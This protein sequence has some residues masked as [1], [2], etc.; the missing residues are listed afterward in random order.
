MKE[1]LQILPFLL[2]GGNYQWVIFIP[3]LWA[4]LIKIIN[5]IK[6]KIYCFNDITI[7]QKKHQ[8]GQSCVDHNA[9]YNYVLWWI[10]DENPTISSKCEKTITNYSR[11]YRTST[12]IC[13]Y[14][15]IPLYTPTNNVKLTW[16]NYEYNISV[17]EN[18]NESFIIIRGDIDKCKKLIDH[19]KAEYI[20]KVILVDD[21]DDNLYLLTYD[22]KNEQWDK[23]IIDVNKTFDNVINPNNINKKIINDLDQFI[24]NV[25]YYKKMGIPYKRGYL[26][27]GIPGTGKSSTIYAISSKM[28]RNMYKIFPKH[29]TSKTFIKAI[30]NIK[31]NSI[32]LMEEIDIHVDNR[33]N[34]KDN[35]KDDIKDYLKL[36]ISTILDILDGYQYLHNCIIILTTNYYDKLD[37]ALI[38]P[39]RIDMQIEFTELSYTDIQNIIKLYTS[40]NLAIPGKFTMTSAQ[41]INEIIMPNRNNKKEIRR[42]LKLK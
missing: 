36:D 38:R 10:N 1:L 13:T 42:L 25:D 17:G 23:N 20:S 28:N 18:D 27:Y 2:V 30:E 21:K 3:I 9:I 24:N 7:V 32:L 5:L 37:K 35:Q 12:G 31:P 14:D 19:S 40:Y 33:D 8:K 16:S 29:H 22:Q 26:F 11:P 4:F 41:L 34:Q 15:Q 6:S 39:G